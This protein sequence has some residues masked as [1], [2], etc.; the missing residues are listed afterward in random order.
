M[1]NSR[2]DPKGGSVVVNNF[3]QL[4]NSSDNI[5]LLEQQPNT[6]AHV[7]LTPNHSSPGQLQDSN[8][9]F[10]QR[11][12]INARM[13]TGSTILGKYFSNDPSFF[14]IYEPGHFLMKSGALNL[15]N[16]S[17]DY[18][19]EIQRPMLDYIRDF[20]RC[21]FRHHKGFFDHLQQTHSSSQLLIG[22]SEMAA[23]C[24]S[25]SNFVTKVVRLNDISVAY[26][27]IEGG[28]MKVIHLVRDPRGMVSSREVFEHLCYTE[29]TTTRM[30]A[31]TTFKLFTQYYCQWLEANIKSILRG[32]AWLQE[33][34]IIVRYEDLADRPEDIV[35]KL[36]DFIGLPMHA[37]VKRMF[38]DVDPKRGNGEAWRYKLP[39]NRTLLVQD[40]CSDE[41]F[42]AF[43]YMKIG[44]ESDLRDK[45]I[46]VMSDI[47]D[48]KNIK[49][50]L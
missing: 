7:S 39:Y 26:D 46:S 38:I 4:D 16:D 21:D 31:I 42:R 37:D 5:R 32:P 14:Y 1:S 29:N 17:A 49:I 23:L 9:S 50:A 24:M 44:N 40:I 12:L 20:F 27:L 36:Y 2:N 33:H 48:F 28:N 18:M 35:P 34:L 45:D 41:V 13:R 6:D 30:P 8:H 19:A 10:S 22:S 3:K 43:G 47:V 11:I 15:H 25:K